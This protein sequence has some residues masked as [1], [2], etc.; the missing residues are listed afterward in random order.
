MK[1]LILFLFAPSVMADELYTGWLRMYDLQFDEAHQHF[2]TWERDHAANPMG[3]ASHAAGYLFAEFARLGVLESE[4]FVQDKN[5]LGRQKL[6]P[7][8]QARDLFLQEVQ[9]TDKLADSALALNSANE[10]ALLA[11][12][13]ALGLR[14]DYFGMI[15]KQ[16]LL[17]LKLTKES[18]TYAERLLKIDP[19]DY[20]AN[21]GPGVENYL[22]SLKPA[23]IRMVLE[24]TGSKADRQAGVEQIKLTAARG[25]LLE[26]FAKLLLAVAALRDK[27]TDLAKGILRELHHRFPDNPLYLKEIERL[28]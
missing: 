26:P 5:W 19:T 8:P 15:E 27:Q 20:D 14:A 13:L 25:H 1:Y 28:H 9:R 12:S 11:K 24:W 22:L 6:H 23:P 18:R 4:L 17:P 21:L 16:N 7:D 10:D 2:K 3:P